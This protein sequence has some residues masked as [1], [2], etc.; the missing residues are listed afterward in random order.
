MYHSR[1]GCKVYKFR[2]PVNHNPY[3]QMAKTS[4]KNGAV[5]NLARSRWPTKNTPR[6]QQHLIPEVTKDPTTTSKEL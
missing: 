3:P 2:T 5:V 1:K 6:T 4:K